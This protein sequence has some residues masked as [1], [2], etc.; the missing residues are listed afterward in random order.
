VELHGFSCNVLYFFSPIAFVLWARWGAFVPYKPGFQE[1]S[2]NP[3]T[4]YFVVFVLI[5]IA[6]VVG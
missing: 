6:I 1:L 2:M 3:R 4:S 5:L